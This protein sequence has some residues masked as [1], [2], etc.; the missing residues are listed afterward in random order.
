M[1]RISTLTGD[2]T[3]K[4]VLRDQIL[5]RERGSRLTVEIEH[6]DTRRDGQTCLGGPNSQALTEIQAE[7]GD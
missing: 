3:P 1:R 4:L 5:R 7:C 6:P 2:G